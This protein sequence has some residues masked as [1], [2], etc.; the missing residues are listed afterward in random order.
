[1]PLDRRIELRIFDSIGGVPRGNPETISNVWADR[2]GASVERRWEKLASVDG[3]LFV[4]YRV[5]WRRDIEAIIPGLLIVRDD[6]EN[7]FSVTGISTD[8]RRRS[9]LTLHCSRAA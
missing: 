2:L 6:Q 8:D 3:V 9:F 1:M 4:D 5:R 7:E